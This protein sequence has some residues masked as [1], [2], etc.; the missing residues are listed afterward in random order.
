[1][2]TSAV[3]AAIPWEKAPQLARGLSGSRRLQA[4]SA[5]FQQQRT[6]AEA[7]LLQRVLIN[8]AL[9]AASRLRMSSAFS[10]AR[11]N[12][13]LSSLS[14]PDAGSQLCGQST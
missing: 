1:M 5:G 8:R 6:T 4:R 14:V 7:R 9:G 12:E 3:E 13:H 2:S 10:F 11:R